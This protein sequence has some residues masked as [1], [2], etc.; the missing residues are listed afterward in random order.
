MV[1]RGV[2]VESL[3]LRVTTIE[4]FILLHH[5]TSC[6]PN[7]VIVATRAPAYYNRVEPYVIIYRKYFI[8]IQ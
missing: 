4:L 5:I 8:V 7:K 1:G 2:S 3:S 6:P